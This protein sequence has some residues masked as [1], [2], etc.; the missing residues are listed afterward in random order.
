MVS[1]KISDSCYPI[2]I[3]MSKEMRDGTLILNVVHGKELEIEYEKQEI[4][5]QINA[6]FGYSCISKITL[7][8]I[9]EKSHIKKTELPQ[10][11][12]FQKIKS[13]IEQIDNNQLKNS[14]N[15]FLKS[16]NAKNK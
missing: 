13:K 6:F 15:D 14:L 10:I 9:R 1:K 4:I 2:S 8:I 11:K 12:N 16:Y 7:K 5:D 3:K